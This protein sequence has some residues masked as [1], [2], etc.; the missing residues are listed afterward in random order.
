MSFLK[1]AKE[2][3]SVCLVRRIIVPFS[4]KYIVF[5]SDPDFSDNTFC[6]YEKLKELGYDRK[7]DFIWTDGVDEFYNIT[8]SKVYKV[9]YNTLHE[10]YFFHRLHEKVSCSICC[11][12]FTAPFSDEQKVFYVS[13]GIPIKSVSEYYNIPDY[14]DYCFCTSKN[15]IDLYSKELKVTK[16]K[17]V[18]FGFPR[19]DA[20]ARSEVDLRQ[21]LCKE[22][23]KVIAW[24]PTFR[25]HKSVNNLTASNISVPIIHNSEDAVRINDFAKMN[26]LLIVMK[27]HFEQ[28]ISFIKNQ[29][30]SNLMIIDDEFLSSK[31]VLLYD[32]I[33]SC[34]ALLTDYS[35]VYYDFTL[36]DKPIGV[37]WEDIDDYK[38]NPGFAV[39]LDYY[40]KGA[41][42][43]YKVDD[44]IAFLNHLVLEK[45]VLKSERREIRDFVNF[46]VDEKNTERVTNFIIEKA[47]L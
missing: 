2:K 5:E 13:H 36:A 19:N 17:V 26:R 11:N 16:S 1:K 45:D 47:S 7:Y 3:I 23:D 22:F 12:R 31:Q 8:K 33:H 41:E 6:V 28:D 34:D 27:P 43:I 44:F 9:G 38:E 35:S 40:L 37:I 30:L 18:P 32:F 25:Q 14:V 15:V 39:D 24:L 10:K 4:K 21:V 42:K 29:N 46:S 20:F